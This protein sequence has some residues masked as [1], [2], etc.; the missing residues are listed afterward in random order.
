MIEYLQVLNNNKLIWGITMILMNVGSR[1]IITD[2]GRIHEKILS[3]EI[4]KKIIIFSMF[5]VATRDILTAF[6]LTV[7]YT[8]IVDGIL[9]EKRRFCIIPKRFLNSQGNAHHVSNEDYLKA[10]TIVENYEKKAQLENN[11]NINLFDIYKKNLSL[12]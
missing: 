3:S 7:S 1:Y 6:M 5:F 8:F 10:K 2:M 11:I 12:I 4:V 9:H